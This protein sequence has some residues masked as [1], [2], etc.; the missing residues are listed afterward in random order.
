MSTAATFL[1]T[2]FFFLACAAR[3]LLCQIDVVDLLLVALGVV[4]LLDDGL[5]FLL[6]FLLDVE[7]RWIVSDKCQEENYGGDEEN[8]L[9]GEDEA[10]VRVFFKRLFVVIRR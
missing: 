2:A 6:P 10:P 9:Y 7:S 3:I 8:G 1:V 4:H 5:G